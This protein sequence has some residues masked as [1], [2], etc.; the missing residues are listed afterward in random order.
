MGALLRYSIKKALIGIP[1][2]ILVTFILFLI[3]KS[4]P[5]DPILI[6]AGDRVP[7]ARILELR[8]EWGLDKPFLV[9]YFYWFSKIMTGD[10][11]YS[12]LTRQPV[13]Y[14][15]WARLPYTLELT[16]PSLILSY[17]LGVPFGIIAALRRGSARDHLTMAVLNFFYSMPTYWLGLMLM[18]VFG[19][20]LGMFPIS[21]A[22]SPSSIVLPTITLT[23]PFLAYSARIARTEMLDVLTE[24]YMRTAWAKGLKSRV[25]ILKH[26]LRNALIPITVLF[27]LDLPWIIGGAVIVETVFSWPGMGNLLYK[28]IV[29]LDYS[30][31]QAIVLV[32]A[33]LIV[34]SN[35][36]GD[37]VAA[38][39]D[40]RIRIEP[41]K[42]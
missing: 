23:I 39:L 36:L 29:R 9:Q 20:Y 42:S 28:S 31:I 34:I 11:G 4:V 40:P 8:R 32:I 3:M 33:I 18:L 35:I 38:S 12:I 10:F 6:I 41:E 2:V 13:S 14:L 1:V 27:F 7:A 15:I 19:L 21:G 5:A 25:V 17:V 22:S 30:V 24:D 16:V 37:I 26:G